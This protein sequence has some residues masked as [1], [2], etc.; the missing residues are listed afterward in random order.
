MSENGING[1]FGV[2][3]ELVGN[4]VGFSVW[5][6]VDCKERLRKVSKECLTPFSDEEKLRKKQ[7]KL[8]NGA[9]HPFWEEKNK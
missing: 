3:G 1:V 4:W 5:S 2:M 9:W 6:A 8:Q 7:E